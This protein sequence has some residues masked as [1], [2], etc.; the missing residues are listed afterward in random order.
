MSPDSGHPVQGAEGDGDAVVGD[1]CCKGSTGIL[2]AGRWGGWRRW[3]SS[4]CAWGSLSQSLEVGLDFE[5]LT[6]KALRCD[7]RS[8]ET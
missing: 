1:S 8:S 2:G 4:D 5:I 7:L 3:G 6:F